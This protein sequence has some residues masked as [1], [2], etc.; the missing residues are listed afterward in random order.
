[1]T[2]SK[3]LS[4]RTL[5]TQAKSSFYVTTPIFYVNAGEFKSFFFK[6]LSQIL[7]PF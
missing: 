4:Y 2:L 7:I 3:I 5:A 1:M 6:N